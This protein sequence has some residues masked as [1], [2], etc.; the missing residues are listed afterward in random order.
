ME[1]SD[2]VRVA[3]ASSSQA[4]ASANG[5]AAEGMQ[6]SDLSG[7]VRSYNGSKG[8][9]FITGQGI[10][11]DVMFSRHELPEDAREVRG[12][13]LEGRQVVFDAVISHDGRAKS[14]GLIIPN[15]DGVFLPGM[16]KSYSEKNG[17]GFISSS[18]IPSE[19]IRFSK[20]DFPPLIPGINL[21]GALVIFQKQKQT[22][23]K[24]RVIKIQFQTARIAEKFKTFSGL[25][26]SD[27]GAAHPS[28]QPT[29]GGML[30][31]M[32][33]SFSE[34]NGY[35]FIRIPGQPSD[36]M[37]G[38]SDVS[39]GSIIVGTN[40]QF[41]LAMAQDGRVRAK[42][43]HPHA[44]AVTNGKGGVVAQQGL[45][46]GGGKRTSSMPT[47]LA[48][49]SGMRMSGTIKSFN[50]SKGFGFITSPQLSGDIFFMKSN[51]PAEVQDSPNP[52]LPG[53]AVEF[54]LMHTQDGN[55]RAQNL[56]L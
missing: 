23:G 25:D 16:V 26:S 36:I 2:P 32:V 14:T 41:L 29:I 17:Y 42:Q 9:G 11:S 6:A 15:S 37:F 46:G 50:L 18:S 43:V 45:K 24:L 4:V 10:F 53:Q 3:V 1:A 31:G 30:T 56:A 22:D 51:L 5:G 54:E 28:Y 21:K 47:L 40:V 35:G 49:P 48:A 34:K 52:H 8:F 12:K 19:D 13:F 39:G 7:I 20:A 33:K 38:K 55:L 44:A 27:Q